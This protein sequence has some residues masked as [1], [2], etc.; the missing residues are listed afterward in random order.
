MNA[1]KASTEASF[2]V[3]SGYSDRSITTLLMVHT[4]AWSSKTKRAQ[5]HLADQSPWRE[6]QARMC[7]S[8]S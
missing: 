7:C 5:K 8:L 3:F 6:E 2:V 1:R 4:V